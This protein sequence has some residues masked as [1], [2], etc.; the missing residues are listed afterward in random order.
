M[1]KPKV[2]KKPIKFDSY[3]ALL[4]LENVDVDDTYGHGVQSIY[5]VHEIKLDEL[6]EFPN[7]PFKVI[8]DKKMSELVESITE[9]GLL[10]PGIATKN[11]EGGYFIISGHRRARACKL[12]GKDVMPFWI[13]DTD[14]ETARIMMV[15]SNFQQRD[16]LLP[17]EKAKAYRQKY[18]VIKHQGKRGL[19]SSF[20]EV[21]ETTGESGR[22]VQ[23]FIRLS[24]LSDNLLE[25]VDAGKLGVVQG[26]DISFL[27]EEKQSVV[28]DAI[29]QTGIS[30]SKEQAAK[31]KEYGMKG[32]LIPEMVMFILTDKK[33]KKRQFLLKADKLSEYF[34][35]DVSE[36]EIEQVILELLD[37]WKKGR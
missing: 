5:S 22:T 32:N 15:D 8:D 16:E 21:G 17:S 33:P 34:S 24:Y 27:D 6:K 31:I 1:S 23:R 7:H 25:L 20:D 36:D 14:M 4:G 10:H 3:K 13:L 19:G 2:E 30:M 9:Y 11:P 29:I 35:E 37:G 12:S 26:V 18:D 28:C